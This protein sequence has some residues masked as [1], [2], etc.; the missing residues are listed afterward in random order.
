MSFNNKPATDAIPAF[1]EAV[2]PGI[3]AL[4]PVLSAAL[5]NPVSVFL[6]IF[7]YFWLFLLIF[8]Y[9][10]WLFLVILVWAIRLTSCFLFTG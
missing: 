6:V 7:G 1:A 3:Q 9:Y 2:A 4:S 8:A 5:N 10:F